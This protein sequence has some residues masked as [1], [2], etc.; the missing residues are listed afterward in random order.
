MQELLKSPGR[1]PIIL[2]LCWLQAV[3]CG[4]HSSVK[5]DRQPSGLFENSASLMDYG[6]FETSTEAELSPSQLAG[7]DVWYKATAGNSRFHEYS[8]AQRIAGHRIDWF[9]F[10]N[11]AERGTRFNNWGLI[12]DPDCCSP[13]E[14]CRRKFN[15]QISADQT[16]G[17]DYCKGDEKLY[18][19]IGVTNVDG[20]TWAESADPACQHL[21][22]GA[23]RGRNENAC[24]LEFGQPL[25]AIGFRKF[26]NPRFNRNQW[27]RLNGSLTD[28]NRFRSRLDDFSVEPPFLIGV[29]CASCHAGF[30][31][32]HPPLNANDPTW[33]NIKGTVGSQYGR[34]AEIF[35]SGFDHASLERQLYGV[36]RPGTVDTSGIPS[37]FINNPGSFTSILNFDKRP[38]FTEQTNT[39]RPVA[40]CTGPNSPESGCWC[41]PQK[42]GKCWLKAVRTEAGIPHL[43]KGGEDS[44]GFQGAIHRVY[45][46]TGS[47]SEQCWV[48]HLTDFRAL[49]PGSRNYT[50]TPF[51][52]GQ[53]R[54]DCP[55]FRAV[56]DR[57][58]DLVSFLATR[59]TTDL[60]DA[61]IESGKTNSTRTAPEA[62]IKD[63]ADFESY[64]EK[65][66]GGTLAR[67]EQVFKRTCARCHSSQE[68]NSSDFSDSRSAEFDSVNLLATDSNGVRIDWLGNDKSTR[69]DT[70]KTFSCRAL[71]SNH[72]QG[73]IWAEYASD[74]YHNRPSVNGVSGG[75]GY[76]RNVSLLNLWT[77]APFLHNNAVGPEMCPVGNKYPVLPPSYSDPKSSMTCEHFDPSIDARLRIFDLS[78][79]EL[80]TPSLRRNLKE[81]LTQEDIFYPLGGVLPKVD[82]STVSQI[83]I[84]IPKGVN[85]NRL[86]N[87]DFKN[88][89]ADFVASLES[90]DLPA[91]L[92]A[93]FGA[94]L[95][96][97]LL[98]GFK[99]L[100]ASAQANLAIGSGEIIFSAENLDLFSKGYATCIERYD[101]G[102][103]DFGTSLS[104][105]D[106]RSLTAYMTLF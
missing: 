13:G 84:K 14:D 98:G 83:A 69:Y 32:A 80:L 5:L 74:T 77:Q 22:P 38:K 6:S 10:F 71:H 68:R 93:R 36:A 19:F 60:V 95:S 4:C 35:S 23:T 2:V 24:H 104:E 37:D 26:P 1:W 65:R 91:K 53:C 81:P 58:E 25:G 105:S 49:T 99:R 82:T 89:A 34:M 56:E 103:H 42:P 67:G 61:M 92:G 75:R 76:M 52:V 21:D 17:F 3:F 18:P 90:T 86:G 28:W 30:H 63:Q 45:I 43:L 7:R 33:A 55:Q 20:Q 66:F 12:N 85:L 39:W 51:D 101:N 11:S 8:F 54:R 31:P 46:N 97:E 50:Q 102:G 62:Q 96:A 48:N 70:I 44:I 16:F 88:F 59:R 87:F 73:H 15:M 94:E 29:S 47:C 57:I 106:K 64:I 100:Q 72:L 40:S 79:R 27:L 9:K 41:E 78:M